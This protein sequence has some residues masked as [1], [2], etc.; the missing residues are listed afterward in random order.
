[1]RI[2]VAEDDPGLRAVLTQ[3]L[4]D[5]GYQVDAVARGDDA[6]DQLRYYDYDV[7]IIDWRMPGVSGI[8]V[9]AWARHHDRPTA[10]LMLTAL[11]TPSDRVRGLD[12][13]ARV[14]STGPCSRA[15]PWRSI[16]FA[17]R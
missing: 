16:R 10:L 17:A 5:G 3:G 7:A 13:G 4:E 9:V 2:L 11:D 12:S 1:M 6:I 14:A 15:G 8:E